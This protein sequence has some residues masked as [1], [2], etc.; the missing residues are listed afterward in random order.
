MELTMWWT[1]WLAQGLG[2]RPVRVR[3]VLTTLTKGEKMNVLD[4][5]RMNIHQNVDK[6]GSLSIAPR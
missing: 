6:T 1:T 5:E 2:R 4:A 3:S